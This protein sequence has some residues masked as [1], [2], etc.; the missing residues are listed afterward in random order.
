MGTVR[1]DGRDYWLVVGSSLE[2]DGMFLECTLES[3]G[4]KVLVKVF[5][6]D[7]DDTFT[8]ETCGEELPL[9]LVKLVIA[10]AERRLPRGSS[11]QSRWA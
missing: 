7:E 2:P 10:E 6:S 11:D 4:T 1:I 8:I 9:A 5:Y 3:D